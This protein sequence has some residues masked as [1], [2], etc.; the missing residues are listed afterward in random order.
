MH[1]WIMSFFFLSIVAVAL[2]L[3]GVITGMAWVGQGVVVLFI[4]ALIAGFAMH[5]MNDQDNTR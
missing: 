1:Y 4:I 5:V 3:G 2:G